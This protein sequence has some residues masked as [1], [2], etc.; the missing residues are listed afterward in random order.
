MAAN[1]S[2]TVKSVDISWNHREL[3]RINNNVMRNLFKMAFQ[4]GNQARANAP[5]V[6]GALRNS[7]RIETNGNEIWIIAGGESANGT[8]PGTGQR[9][10]RFVDYAAKVERHSSSPHYMQRAQ[11][12]IMSGDWVAKYF[13]GA[14][15]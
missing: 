6:T 3:T 14:T 15:T 2:V 9:I 7:I 10:T 1:S 4:I 8:M 12:Q 11:E 5:V 13:K